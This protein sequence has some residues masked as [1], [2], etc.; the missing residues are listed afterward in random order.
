MS[1]KSQKRKLTAPAPEPAPGPAEPPKQDKRKVTFADPPKPAAEAP[2]RL[3]CSPPAA[4]PN[5]VV[6][7]CR[8]CYERSGGGPCY[9]VGGEYGRRRYYDGYYERPVYDSRGGGDCYRV[10]RWDYFSD[11]NPNA[12]CT[13]MQKVKVVEA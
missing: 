11:E 4:Y 6:M 7:C 8:E 10:D 12:A 5:P 2:E 3:P 9:Q 1:L 13:I